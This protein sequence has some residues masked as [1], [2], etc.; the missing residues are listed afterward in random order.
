VPILIGGHA[1]YTERQARGYQRLWAGIQSPRGPDLFQDRSWHAPYSAIGIRLTGAN[2]AALRPG[3]K[4]HQSVPCDG[5]IVG[6]RIV[7][8]A[9]G[10]IVF[11]IYRTSYANF[12]PLVR[13]SVSPVASARPSLNNAQANQ[14]FRLY[15]WLPTLTKEDVLAYE[16]LSCSGINSATLSLLIARNDQP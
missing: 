15:G 3:R 8:N 10:S 2:G 7:A 16:V 4:A 11:D 12:P 1:P 13:D 5:Q 14:D 6:Y 9:V